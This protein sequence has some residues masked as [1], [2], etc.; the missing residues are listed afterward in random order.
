MSVIPALERQRQEDQEFKA[1]LRHIAR[2]RL[3]WTLSKKMKKQNIPGNGGTCSKYLRGGR[4]E[5]FKLE[6]S[7]GKVSRTTSQKQNMNKRAESVM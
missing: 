1:S 6:A 4:Q 3:T 5:D 7:P 2:S